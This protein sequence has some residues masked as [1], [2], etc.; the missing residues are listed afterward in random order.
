MLGLASVLIWLLS[1]VGGQSALRLIDQ[2][3]GNVQFNKQV[4]YLHPTTFMDSLMETANTLSKFTCAK[5]ISDVNWLYT[6][7][8]RRFRP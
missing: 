7:N 4:R 6:Y 3:I 5:R 1:P 8:I 2:E